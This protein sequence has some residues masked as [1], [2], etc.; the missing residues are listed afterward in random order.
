MIEQQRA[1]FIYGRFYAK[2]ISFH[3]NCLYV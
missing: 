2:S 3:S 1:V